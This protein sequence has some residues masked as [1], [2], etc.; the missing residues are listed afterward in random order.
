[1]AIV[2]RGGWDLGEAQGQRLTARGVYKSRRANTLHYV[3]QST[4]L[5]QPSAWKQLLD[6]LWKQHWVVYS[7]PPFGGPE[8]VL[9]YLS[10]YTHRVAISNRR[11]LAVGNGIVRFE[12]R[13]YAD[14]NKRKKWRFL[15]PSSC[16]ASCSTLFPQASCVSATTALLPTASAVTSS[17]GVERSLHSPLPQPSPKAKRLPLANTLP[18]PATARRF[19]APSVLALCA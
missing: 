14:D 9:K 13:D 7:K 8:Q 5:Q 17:R 4:A 18:P 6:E 1:M 19:V 10:R 2:E 15:P 12:Y 16:A 11:I 3:G